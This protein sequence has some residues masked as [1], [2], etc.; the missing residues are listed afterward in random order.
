M[1]SGGRGGGSLSLIR[2]AKNFLQFTCKNVNN[3][4]HM[5]GVGLLL[6]E[7]KN[8]KKENWIWNKLKL[9]VYY[10]PI[11]YYFYPTNGLGFLWFCDLRN[12]SENSLL[13]L[14]VKFF[15]DESPPPPLH[16]KKRCYAPELLPVEDVSCMKFSQLNMF[17][18]NQLFPIWLC[19]RIFMLNEAVID[20]WIPFVSSRGLYRLLRKIILM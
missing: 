15:S 4:W 1:G 11:V 5:H 3:Y 7:S 13:F 2:A 19:F 9:W 18:S 6:L 14:L 10:V 12:L 20:A 17:I 16:F 8:K